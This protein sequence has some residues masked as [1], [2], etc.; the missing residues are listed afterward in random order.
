MLY[1][2]SVRLYFI[3]LKNVYYLPILLNLHVTCTKI[4][5]CYHPIHFRLVLFPVSLSS[6]SLPTGPQGG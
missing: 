4:W 6:S 2:A 5:I 3:K 1:N